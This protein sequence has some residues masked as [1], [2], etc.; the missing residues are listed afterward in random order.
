MTAD[1]SRFTG[2]WSLSAS[3]LYN[4]FPSL[5]LIHRPEADSL[6]FHHHS[7]TMFRSTVLFLLFLLVSTSSSISSDVVKSTSAQKSRWCHASVFLS[8]ALPVEDRARALWWTIS[9]ADGYGVITNKRCVS[10]ATYQHV[11]TAHDNT[12]Y[13]DGVPLEVERRIDPLQ[14]LTVLDVQDNGDHDRLTV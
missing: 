10:S 9:V 14:A 3:H 12:R 4:V 2:Q 7:F 13:S 5:S 6:W 8:E 11:P 1:T